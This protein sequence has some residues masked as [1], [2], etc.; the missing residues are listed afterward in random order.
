MTAIEEWMDALRGA[1]E[2]VVNTLLAG[3]SRAACV[4]VPV[5][6][7]YAQLP[8]ELCLGRLYSASAQY[9][10]R[11]SLNTGQVTA[12]CYN[13][14]RECVEISLDDSALSSVLR[15]VVE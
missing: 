3:I 11:E 14:S 15:A 2:E 10:A 1:L 4:S 13:S 8:T 5:T 12:Q 9:C 7:P 6:A